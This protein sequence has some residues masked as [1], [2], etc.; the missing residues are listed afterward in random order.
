MVREVQ[1]GSRQGQER[2]GHFSLQV[3]PSSTLSGSQ[4]L[5]PQAKDVPD[6]NN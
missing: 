2:R 6:A 3:A 1:G 4:Q 5:G